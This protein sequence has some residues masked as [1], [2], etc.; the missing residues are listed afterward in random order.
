ML[1]MPRI[2]SL[3]SVSLLVAGAAFAQS[4]ATSANTTMG[5]NPNPP[6]TQT[7]PGKMMNSGSSGGDN[8]KTGGKMGGNMA[9][10]SM[11][12]GKSMHHRMRSHSGGAK[13]SVWNDTTRLEA[14]LTDAQTNASVSGDA[15]KKVA[16]EANSLASRVY[17]HASGNATARSAARDL[18][19]HVRELHTA[20]MAG[21]AAGVRT[22][23]SM[24]L[25][26]AHKLVDWSTPAG[27]A[28]GM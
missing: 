28:H 20:A 21:D 15:W 23:A 27:G 25:P 3:V 24:A 16:N 12:G 9:A 4:T 6:A 19:T 2:S 14:L 17:V 18:R 8:G 11:S 13:G 1:T 7:A 22:H 26:Y 10:G 5:T